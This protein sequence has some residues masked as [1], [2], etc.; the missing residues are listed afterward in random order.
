LDNISALRLIA[1]FDVFVVGGPGNSWLLKMPAKDNGSGWRI[2][3]HAAPASA[4]F[5]MMTQPVTSTSAT[6]RMVSAPP[7]HNH[8]F[9][10]KKT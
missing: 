3:I 10:L 9:H 2:S 7:D 5:P 4:A 6:R 1:F 8:F